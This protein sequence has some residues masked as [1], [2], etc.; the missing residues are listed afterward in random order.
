M[1]AAKPFIGAYADVI[2][3]Y[4]N[5][6]PNARRRA[7]P[8][9]VSKPRVVLTPAEIAALSLAE[10]LAIYCRVMRETEDVFVK[11][12]SCI[13]RLWDGM[14]GCWTDCTGAVGRE[15]ALR[16]WAAKTD[17]GAHHASYDEIDYYRI[18]PAT[19]EMLWDGSPRGEIHR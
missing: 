15:E 14:D 6:M 18:S 4:V 19:R 17:G 3:T 12:E 16:H 13:V 10:L 1:L 7:F 11:Y 9:E 8:G 5:T 2:N